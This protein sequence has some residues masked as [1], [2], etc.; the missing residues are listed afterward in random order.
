MEL[1]GLD[2]AADRVLRGQ[3]VAAA[4]ETFFG[5]L[6]LAD[7]PVALDALASVKPRGTDKGIPLLLPARSEWQHWVRELPPLAEQ[8]ADH[9]WPGPLTIALRARTGVDHRVTLDGSLAVRLPG[10]CPAAMI[11]RRVGRALTATSANP[12][13]CPPAATSAQACDAL[14]AF[15]RASRLSIVDGTA[16]GGLPSTVLA[17]AGQRVQLLREGA[18]SFSE[19]ERVLGRRVGGQ[20][21][22]LPG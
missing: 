7:D 8:L 14:G 11:A 3:V 20:R 1:L 17:V 16:P 2:E 5:L 10:E 4:T 12:P 9:F 21:F 19:I 13:G 6:A 18:V 15:V 22:G